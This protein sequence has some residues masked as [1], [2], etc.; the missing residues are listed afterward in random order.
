MECSICMD[1][2]DG[3]SN[4]SI[5]EC[6]HT[7]HHKCLY[8]WNRNH[9]NCPLCRKEF[10]EIQHTVTEND[11]EEYVARI[12]QSD[13]R[14]V[15]ITPPSQEF[16]GEIQERDVRLVMSYVPGNVSYQT[17]QACMRQFQGDM[18]DT[19]IYLTEHRGMPIPE[20]QDR[21]RPALSE[22]Y[23]SRNIMDRVVASRRREAD[24]G[25]ESS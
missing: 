5:T 6:G 23:V 2:I 9:T 16:T 11:V 13:S 12:L 14:R 19:I 10:E 18:V 21:F 17:V 22:P 1:A 3:N 24:L 25:Y 7:F 8:K 4:V 15:W 20:Y